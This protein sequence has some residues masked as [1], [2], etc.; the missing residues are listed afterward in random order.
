MLDDEYYIKYRRLRRISNAMIFSI[1]ALIIGAL[2]VYLGLAGHLRDPYQSIAPAIGI[3][4]IS[5]SIFALAYDTLNRQS[6]SDEI[7]A[8]IASILREHFSS[9]AHMDD[10]GLVNIHEVMPSAD[11]IKA[12][13]SAENV[14]ILQSWIPD[15]IP[16]RQALSRA[17]EKGAEVR[18]LMMDPSSDA[19]RRRNKELGYRD[20]SAAARAIEGSLTELDAITNKLDVRLY[21][22]FSSVW[23]YRVD[24]EVFGGAFLRGVPAIQSLCLH[25]R[26][27]TE[28]GSQFFMHFETIW[29]EAAKREA[30]DVE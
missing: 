17:V 22:G 5:S 3:A 20:P 14:D 4:F 18:I 26:L 16:M 8:T 29:Q 13:A 7:S 1:V 19:V 9:R 21:S 11:V 2:L 6:F 24:G 27:D 23:L 12:I 10:I 28:L 25:L 15:V 30:P